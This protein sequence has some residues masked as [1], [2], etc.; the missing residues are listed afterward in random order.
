VAH[1]LPERGYTYL[2]WNMTNPLFSSK[3]VR[4][5]LTMAINRKEIIDAAL[6]QFGEIA[7]GPV[8][9]II[10][11]YNP[12]IR[13]FAFDPERAKKHLAEE[14]WTDTD[15]DG[16]IDKNG[17]KF[18]FVLKTNKGNQIR[19]DLV[20]IIQDML[21]QVGI[22]V[23]PQLK[24]GRTFFKDLEKKEFEAAIAG[25]MVGLKM[26]LTTLWH[27]KSIGDKF[28]FCSYSNPEVDRLND[29]AKFEMDAEKSR[30]LWGKAQALIADDQPYTFLFIQKNI[31]WVHKRFQNVHMKTI[32]WYYNLEEW[33]VPKDERKFKNP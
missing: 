4:Q 21:K 29:I 1:V 2:A 31:N 5:A 20:V 26:D 27:T 3:K 11:A 13:D 10:W 24:E 19:E 32:G 7:K 9:P 17:T 30:E 28:N 23:T 22:E 6:F 16:W 12:D 14:G 15:G 33:W 25:W 18:S 8:S